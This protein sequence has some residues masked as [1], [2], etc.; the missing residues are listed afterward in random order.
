M[1]KERWSMKKVIV[2]SKLSC[3]A[4]LSVKSYIE[5]KGFEYIERDITVYEEEFLSLG[6][7]S[8]PVIVIDGH[9]PIVGFNPIALEQALE[10][11]E[12]E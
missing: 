3:P 4:C 6:Y 11:L 12:N 1:R 8:V 7:R 5:G 10:G 2:Y 9:E